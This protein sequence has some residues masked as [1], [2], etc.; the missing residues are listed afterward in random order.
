MIS[1]TGL[2]ALDYAILQGNYL[3]AQ[4]IYGKVKITKAKSPFEYYHIA[5]KYKYRFV[6]FEIVLEALEKGVH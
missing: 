4:Q 2:T 3:C 6:D 1:P 5:Y